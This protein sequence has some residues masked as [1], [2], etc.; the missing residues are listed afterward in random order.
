M[1]L[2]N[3]NKNKGGKKDAKKSAQ[4]GAQGAKAVQKA[5]PTFVSKQMN[6]GSQRGS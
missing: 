2:L 1:S 6:T 4:K 5:K 3:Q